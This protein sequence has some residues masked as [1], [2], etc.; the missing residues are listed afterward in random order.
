MDERKVD[1]WDFGWEGGIMRNRARGESIYINSSKSGT[2]QILLSANFCPFVH[3]Q[4]TLLTATS[5]DVFGPTEL[6]MS[7]SG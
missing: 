2:S 3:P 5:P 6:I 1:V 7:H 4:S